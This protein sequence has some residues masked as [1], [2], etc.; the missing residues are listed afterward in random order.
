MEL[1]IGLGITL[2]NIICY[3]ANV[4]DDYEDFFKF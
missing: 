4:K 1:Y 2:G 3:L